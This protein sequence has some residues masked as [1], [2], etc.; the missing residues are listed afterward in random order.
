[1]GRFENFNEYIDWMYSRGKSGDIPTLENI[2]ILLNNIGNPQDDV[3]IIHVAGT[4]G[5]GSTSNFISSTISKVKKCGL[6]VS[7][8]MFTITDSIKI[9]NKEISESKFIEYLEY[10]FP[11]VE[12][13]DKKGKSVTYFELLTALMFKYFSDEKVDY[14]VVEV[15]LGG[16]WDS[17]NVIKKPLASVITTISMDHINVLGN[18]IEQIAENKAGI[19]K[20]NCP[21]FIYPQLEKVFSVFS[22]KAKSMKSDIYTFTIDEVEIID[23]KERE[24]IFNFRNYKNVKSKLVGIHQVYNASLAIMVLD[25]FKE[26]IGLNKQNILDGIND[27]INVGRLQFVSED[28][29]VI[30][31]GSHNAESIDVLKKSLEAFNYDKLIVGFSVLKDKDYNY[32]I[33]EIASMASEIVVTTIDNP[34]REFKLDELVE[35]VKKIT[36]NAIGI[37]NRI[38]A[39]EYSKTLAGKNDLILWCGSLY[40]IRELLVYIKNSNK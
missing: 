31:D 35:K 19:I 38:E 28:P 37:E 12:E 7:P 9:N 11:Y 18:N 24:N 21:V 20:Q 39:Y 5:K 17:T 29:R 40:L 34:S 25:F 33:K 15:G 26:E 8:Y 13:L 3:K 22:K 10:M 16:E 23:L 36:P 4:N 27:S 2:K 30:F 1:M 6:F 14:A 32:V